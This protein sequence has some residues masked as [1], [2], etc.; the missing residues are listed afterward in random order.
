MMRTVCIITMLVAGCS[1]QQDET[2][3]T[4]DTSTG[5]VETA[6]TPNYCE[7]TGMTERLFTEVDDSTALYATAGDFSVPTTEGTYTL[8]EQWTGC[9]SVLVIPDQPAQATGW[10]KD[11]WQKKSDI[12]DLLGSLPD[13]TQVL[14]VSTEQ[15]SDTRLE[16]LDDL[17]GKVDDALKDIEDSDD[18]E[19][20]IFYVTERARKLEGWLGEVLT[21]PNWG[22]GIDRFQR[23]RYVGSFADPTRYEADYGWFAPNLSMVA[24]EAIYYNFE[25]DR[26]DEMVALGATEIPLWQGDVISDPGWAGARGSIEIELPDAATMAT[27]D[28][29]E[30]ELYLGCDGEGEYGNCP[31]WDYLVYL[32]L[33]DADD[34]DSCGTEIGRW[35]T[36]YHREGRWVHDVTGLLPLLADGGTRKFQFYSQQPYEVDL[37]LRLANQGRELRPVSAT[38]LYTGGSFGETYNDR[39]EEVEVEI[40]ATAARVEIASVISGHGQVS[41]GTCAEFCVTTHH[42]WVNGDENVL[43]LD[44]AGSGYGC[45]EQV[46]EGTV[47]NQYGTWWYGRSNWCPGKEVEL[48]TTDI[49]SQVT[50]GETATFDYEGFYEG[51]PY[52]TGGASIVMSSWV[53]VY[54]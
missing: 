24:N 16:I 25:S 53:V 48:D 46:A 35:I 47:P 1:K 19:A 21:S 50:A 10:P 8:S 9:G 26:D 17:Q 27:Y 52:T 33:C 36:T 4:S 28:T 5:T 22:V 44:D 29:M 3:D 20:R 23:I 11:L 42:F 39:F 7:S 49:T 2:S 13:N 51:A 15:G 37:T 14:F 30:W 12:A 6:T 43:S 45:M 40:P 18:L 34:P 54:E 31:A 32:F 38:P 41:P